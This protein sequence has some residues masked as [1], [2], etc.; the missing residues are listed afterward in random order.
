M[1]DA[2]RLGAVSTRRVG[3]DIL[4]VGDVLRSG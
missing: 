1:A 4:V 2:W 3:D